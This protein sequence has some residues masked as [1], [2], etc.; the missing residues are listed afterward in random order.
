MAQLTSNVHNMTANCLFDPF[1][2]KCIHIFT[3]LVKKR[4]PYTI[5]RMSLKILWEP[6]SQVPRHYPTLVIIVSD[7]LEQ[8]F[9]KVFSNVLLQYDFAG[10]N[11][12]IVFFYALNSIYILFL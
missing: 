1:L 10:F 2:L 9:G 8:F 6:G 3:Y 11:N 5:L 7:H 12:W 4:D